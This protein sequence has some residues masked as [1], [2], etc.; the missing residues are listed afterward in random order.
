MDHGLAQITLGRR[1]D[2]AIVAHQDRAQDFLAEMVNAPSV[3]GQERPAQLV[4]AAEL[5]RLGFEVSWLDIPDSIA[6]DAA[7]GVP[8][9]SYEGRQVLVGRLAGSAPDAGSS[10]LING[11]LDVVPA[12]DDGAWS[13]PPFTAARVD[14]WMH[15]RG[16]GDMKSG[17]AMSTLAIEALLATAGRPHADLTVVGVIEEECTGNGTLASVR[18]G[19][20]ADAVLLP[21]PTNLEV[22]TSGVGVLWVDI[23]IP[24]R[25]GH[26]ES[27]PTAASAIDRIWPVLE[28]LRGLAGE[29]NRDLE[30]P[31]YHVNVGQL[32]AGDW[33]STVPG[34]AELRVRVGFP[35]AMTPR[36]AHALTQAA[37]AEAAAADPWLVDHPPVLRPSGFRAAGYELREDA[38]ILAA[39]R[40]AHAEAHGHEPEIVSINGTTDARFYLNE[41][42]VP[43]L[44]FGPRTRGMHGV[45]EAV[46]LASIAAGARTLARFMAGWLG[47]AA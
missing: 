30:E 9:L 45:D 16:A 39:L 10:L 5:E 15:G 18:A 44:C 14:G 33:P 27:A 28:G 7:A 21:E 13:S 17:L 34:S 37:V 6:E 23:T 32:R 47:G 29:L 3:L 31:R 25:P 35:T 1:L 36:A 26:A 22:S 24:G 46:E 38:A 20:L 4:L 11:H 2:E 12:A 43:A 42:G 8:P 19:V 41:A 40:E